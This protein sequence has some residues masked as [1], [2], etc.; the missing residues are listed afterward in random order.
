VADVES[1]EQVAK[2]LATHGV[3][4]LSDL[5][6]AEESRLQLAAGRCGGHSGMSLKRL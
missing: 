1:I 5:V 3:E 2:V 4:Q 6:V